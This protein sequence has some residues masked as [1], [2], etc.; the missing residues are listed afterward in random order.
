MKEEIIKLSKHKINK[1]IHIKEKPCIMV[2]K[3][4]EST[5]SDGKNIFLNEKFKRNTII[6]AEYQTSGRGRMGREFYSPKSHGLYMSLC[7]TETNVKNAVYLPSLC[8]VAA[9]EA[10]EELTNH[11]TQIKWVNDVY[12]NEK[13]A[14]GIL[15]ESLPYKNITGII[16][17]IGINTAECEFPHFENNTPISIGNVDRNLLAAKIYE[18]IITYM[19]DK[20]YVEKY[21]SRFYLKDKFVTVTDGQNI[22]DAYVLGINNDCGLILDVNGEEKVLNSGEVTLRVK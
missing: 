3:E 12:V 6:L 17:G 9:A 11:K 18:K 21:R 16:M 14:C 22:Y 1:H 5:N 2:K 10:I 7:I 4:T 13:K 8:A 20:S 19:C 15:C